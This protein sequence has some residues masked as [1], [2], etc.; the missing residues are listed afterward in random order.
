MFEGPSTCAI[1]E[2]NWSLFLLRRPTQSKAAHPCPRVASAQTRR[3]AFLAASKSSRSAPRRMVGGTDQNTHGRP[4][5]LRSTIHTLNDN[6]IFDNARLS[7]R[8][9][10]GIHAALRSSLPGSPQLSVSLE[11]PSACPF[12][13]VRKRARQA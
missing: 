13:C 3:I 4:T 9:P 8:G 5:T 2:M 11:P 7:P 12:S 6:N 1:A 10:L